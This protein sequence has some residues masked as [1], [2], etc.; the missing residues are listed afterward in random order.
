[1]NKMIKLRDLSREA[2]G[3]LAKAIPYQK[4]EAPTSNKDY[5]Q[6]FQDFQKATNFT[7]LKDEDGNTDGFNRFQCAVVDMRRSMKTL[8][9]DAK[10]EDEPLLYKDERDW[11]TN[12]RRQ[13]IRDAFNKARMNR[14]KGAMNVG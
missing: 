5:M 9:Y 13:E 11:V 3:I 12:A 2:R 6:L 10:T 4:L 8:E 14:L 1:M 7:Y